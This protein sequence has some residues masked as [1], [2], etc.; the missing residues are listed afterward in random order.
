MRSIVPKLGLYLS[1]E[2]GL[3]LFL[4]FNFKVFGKKDSSSFFLRRQVDSF[5]KT[6]AT[7]VHLKK[8]LDFFYSNGND[9]DDVSK[10]IKKSE[11]IKRKKK[12]R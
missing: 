4:I 5:L 7:A 10:I 12:G 11:I 3:N 6:V 1:G 8:V 2:L 9:E